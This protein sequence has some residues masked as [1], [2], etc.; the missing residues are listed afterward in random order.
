[1]TTTTLRQLLWRHYRGM[2]LPVLVIMG[3]T[4]LKAAT[5]LTQN[6]GKLFNNAGYMA[7][8]SDLLMLAVSVVIAIILGWLMFT[9]DN[10]TAFNHY[11]LAL[12]VTRK[13]IYR[14]KVSMFTGMFIGGYVLMQ[15]VFLSLLVL[16]KR[17]DAIYN[18]NWSVDLR[19]LLSQLAC[20]VAA[21]SVSAVWGLWLGQTVGS[22]IT[23]FIFMCSLP[24]AFDGLM[25]I[26]AYLTGQKPWTINPLNELDQSTWLGF[27]VLI[28]GSLVIWLGCTYLNRW[29]FDHLS[30]ESTGDYFLFPKLRPIFLWGVIAYLTVAVSFSSFGMLL[31]EI[32]TTHYNQ[33][34]PWY[35]SVIMA[36]LVAYLTWSIG[37]W[38]L[39]RPDKIRNA[40]KFKR[41]DNH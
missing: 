15:A 1:M 4:G 6:S 28:A 27:S 5:N 22:A 2:L 11:L 9:W 19:Y 33:T 21:M 16:I 14:A 35:Q 32:V 34:I 31:V 39:Y 30:L 23:T 10:Y 38:I 37:R 26:L 25:N 8:D 3:L 18:L 13:Q 12:P 41:L 7:S 29:A 20:L 40:F 36:I 17:S 24:F